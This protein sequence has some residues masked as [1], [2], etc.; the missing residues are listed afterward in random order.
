MIEPITRLTR[1][2]EKCI[3]GNDQQQ[4]FEKVKAV[5]LQA[6]MLTYPNPNHPLDIYQDASST[7][8][9][10]ALLMQDGNVVSTFSC[11]FNEVQLK[12]TITGQELIAAVEACKHFAQESFEAVRSVST[13]TTRIY[14]W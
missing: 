9:M 8:A 10:G 11:K 4:V 14:L 2:G 13:R 6:I 1:K 3:W 12:Y 7:Y 5:I